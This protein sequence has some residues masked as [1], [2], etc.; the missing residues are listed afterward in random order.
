MATRPA[1]TRLSRAERRERTRDD[2]IAAADQCFVEGGFHAT[3]LDQ[4]AAAAG[5][6]KGAVYSNFAS[7]EDLFFAVYERRADRAEADV[8]RLLADDPRAGLDRLSADTSGR[9]GRDDGWLAAFFEFWAHAIRHPEFRARFASIHRRLQLP[10]ADALERV[11]AARGAELPV[12]ALPLAVASG[13]MQI[14]LALERLT[15]PEVVDE[16]L[17]ARMSRLLLDEIERGTG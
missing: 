8:A 10:V 12:A 2:L 9:H 3:T 11:A 17:G 14:G 16:A 13:A 1:A 5:Y 7:K 6:T 4:I 15:Q